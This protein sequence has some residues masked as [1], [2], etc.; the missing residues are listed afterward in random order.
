[1]SGSV[2]QAVYLFYIFTA[3]ENENLYAGNANVTNDSFS[4][5]SG[6]ILSS[7]FTLQ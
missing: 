2:W 7:L 1:M 6:I 4:G 5:L 3:S